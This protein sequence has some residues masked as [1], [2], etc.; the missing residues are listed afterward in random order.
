MSEI[1]TDKLSPRTGAGT[2][3]LGTSGD[4]YTIPAGV[5][6]TNAGTLTNSGTASGFG[7]VLQV[8]TWSDDT[9]VSYAAQTTTWTAMPDIA[10]SIT[11]TSTSSKILV[12]MSLGISSATYTSHRLTRDGTEIYVGTAYSS[13]TVSSIGVSVYVENNAGGL[14]VSFFDSPSTTSAVEYSLK[15]LTP[16]SVGDIIYLNRGTDGNS[17]RSTG[18]SFITLMEIAG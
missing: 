17:Y 14:N 13:N 11:P 9:H 7:K 2:V 4:S 1:K 8:V 15:Y 12:Q 18:T 5:T 3:T 10:A 16:W 6:L